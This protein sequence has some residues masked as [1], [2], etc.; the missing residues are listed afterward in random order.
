MLRPNL[1]LIKK[2]EKLLNQNLALSTAIKKRC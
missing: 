1:P 2:Q